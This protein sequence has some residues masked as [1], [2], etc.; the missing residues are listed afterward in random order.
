MYFALS[1]LFYVPEN[2]ARYTNLP[3]NRLRLTTNLHG[4]CNIITQFFHSFETSFFKAHKNTLFRRHNFPRCT[5]YT[6]Q[7]A[8]KHLRAERRKKLFGSHLLNLSRSSILPA[9]STGS[10]S[11]EKP[12]ILRSRRE[13]AREQEKG[14]KGRE[15]NS[16]RSESRSQSRNVGSVCNEAACAGAKETRG[17][18]VMAA[19]WRVVNA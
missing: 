3:K 10:N 8:R 7:T 17:P 5:L 9:K 18:G 14:R 4:R 11:I 12:K 1:N 19:C 13:L 15:K 6:S 2:I 16:R